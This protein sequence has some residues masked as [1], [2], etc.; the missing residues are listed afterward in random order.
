[1]SRSHHSAAR[2]GPKPAWR[3]GTR[4]R[5]V[6]A[7]VVDNRTDQMKSPVTLTADEGG[8]RTVVGRRTLSAWP[9]G[10]KYT[11]WSMSCLGTG[12]QRSASAA[13][14]HR[15]RHDQR[16]GASARR[17]VARARVHPD[18]TRLGSEPVRTFASAAA[19]R[20][21]TDSRHGGHRGMPHSVISNSAQGASAHSAWLNTPMSPPHSATTE[22]DSNRYTPSSEPTPNQ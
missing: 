5:I 1:M 9:P 4:P 15:G 13:R 6:P 10:T 22:C 16:A 14:R 21:P 19:A 12:S 17:A 8:G 7:A 11:A 18:S 2:Q 3:G 20:S